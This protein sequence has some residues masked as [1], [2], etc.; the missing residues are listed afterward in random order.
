MYINIVKRGYLIVFTG[1]DGSGKT[2]Q[3]NL[4]IKSL[5]KDGLRVLYAWS[6]WEPFIL[7]PLIK[8]WKDKVKKSSLNNTVSEIKYKKRKLMDNP[9]FRYIWL[10]VFFLEYGTQIFIKITLKLFKNQIII[11]DRIYYDSIIDQAINLGTKGNRLLKTLN[12]WWL[13]FFFPVP[14]IVIYIDCPEDIAYSRKND[15][16]D[17]EYLSDRRRLYLKLADRYSWI[18]IEG[19]HSVEE[20]AKQIKEIVYKKLS[21]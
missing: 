15:A 6:R 21:I 8:K 20:I 4:L 2:T 5:E 18:K 12:S 9:I 7:R 16:P 11:S 17:I 13:K 14:D 3:A 1:I 10:S 19:T